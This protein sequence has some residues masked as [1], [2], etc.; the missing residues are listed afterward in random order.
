MRQFL[1]N[2]K[3]ITALLVLFVAILLVALFVQQKRS[4]EELSAAAGE[5]KFA[6]QQIYSQAGSITSSDGVILAQSVKGEREY[7]E[8][9]ALAK[10]SLHLVGDYTH[11]I[12]NSVE[13]I[14]MPE[15]V[16]NSRSLLDQL[17]LDVRGQGFVGNDLAL[18]VNSD[19]ML[20]AGRLLADYQGSIV[21]LNYE[22]GDLLALVNSPSV[23]PAD[24]VNWENITEGSL[25]NRALYGRYLPGSTVKMISTAAF[26]EA[27]GQDHD[28]E[29]ECKGS[30]PVVPA[31]ANET[32]TP[33]GHGTVELQEAF[34]ESCNAFFGRL[35]IA[36]GRPEIT[37]KL[38]DFGFNRNLNLD[39][40][41]IAQ[42][43]ID[44]QEPGAGALS[45]IGVGQP[46]GQ[47]KLT[48]SPMHLA[49]IAGAIANDGVMVKP[50]VILQETDPLGSVK[51]E[52]KAED[53]FVACRPDTAAELEELMLSVVNSG[54]GRR[55]YREGLS[56]AGKTGTAERI[57][58]EGKIE[59]SSLFAGY[60]ISDSHPLAIAVVLEDE[61]RDAATVAADL[62]SY[63]VSVDIP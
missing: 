4:T 20:R 14:Y 18:T 63:A 46:I 19:L 28:M 31:G 43:Q 37:E 2:L 39:R 53:F 38:E 7:A 12:A 50:R 27:S 49:G 15:L 3:T 62:L 22:T 29:V 1:R 11:R 56:I 8:N 34:R 10:A 9:S 42:S 59:V 26:L 32:L 44:L 57:N 61:N 48:V 41:K 13:S 23:Y 45:W 54:T 58:E 36:L 24:V 40:F 52:R 30:E 60:L 25:F 33:D 35:A 55:A 17:I 5:N 16:G 6:L 47:D 51:Y 21:L